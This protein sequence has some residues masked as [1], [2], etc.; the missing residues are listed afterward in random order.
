MW[1]PW[2]GATRGRHMEQRRRKRDRRNEEKDGEVWEEEK[3]GNKAEE[4]RMKQGL[5]REIK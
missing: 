5:L 1:A 3:Q 4:M 2:L